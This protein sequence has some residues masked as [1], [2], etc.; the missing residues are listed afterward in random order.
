M[1]KILEYDYS[2]FDAR[3]LRVEL[4][5]KL[6][7]GFK[8]K[9]IDL[10]FLRDGHLTLVGLWHIDS[11][12]SHFGNIEKII[13]TIKN[14]ISQDPELNKLDAVSIAE[15]T[16]I[17][18]KAI[19][20]ALFLMYEI[21]GFNFTGPFVEGNYYGFKWAEFQKDDSGLDGF[22]DF[23]NLEQ[24][25]ELFYKR[26]QPVL[27]QSPSSKWKDLNNEQSATVNGKSYVNIGRIN[28]LE[29]ID[30]PNFD[31]TK[32]IQ[33]C[34]ELNKAFSTECFLTCAVLPRAII[35]HVPPIFE[36]KNFAEVC[37]NYR[38][39][40]SFK[41]S[42]KHLDQS[43]RKIADNF[44]HTKIRKQE[45]LPNNTQVDFSND[46]DVLLAEIVRILR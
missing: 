11:D 40:K 20:I 7:R 8:Q 19:E 5:G 31:L 21:G 4:N 39:A 9:E 29:A 38:G 1:S 35:D 45:V 37:N 18:T 14:A 32:L 26:Q 10:R 23:E 44:L 27:P 16:T 22:L 46:L 30:S 34:K 43:S 13:T 15:K 25:I 36:C 6:P 33:L 3:R 12:N 24:H 28:Q 41:A 42:M 2:K 17:D